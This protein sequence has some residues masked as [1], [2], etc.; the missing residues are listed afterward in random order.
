MALQCNQYRQSNRK[1]LTAV[2]WRHHPQEQHVCFPLHLHIPNLA[3]Q[4]RQAMSK[5]PALPG[6]Q[7]RT[8]HF[9][10]KP[11]RVWEPDETVRWQQKKALQYQ[12]DKTNLHKQ[13]QL[14]VL[15]VNQQHQESEQ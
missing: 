8:L 11:I 10:P 4:I 12:E 15:R 3:D 6:N 7:W 1:A 14:E 9:T 2:Q 5:G 13:I